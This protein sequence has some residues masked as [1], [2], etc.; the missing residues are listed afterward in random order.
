MTAASRILIIIGLILTLFGCGQNILSSKKKSTVGEGFNNDEIVDLSLSSSLP[1]ITLKNSSAYPL[2]GVCDSASGIVTVVIGTPNVT[3]IFQCDLSGYFSGIMDVSTVTL[4]PPNIKAS[5]ANQTVSISSLVNDQT[6]ISD[7]PTVADQ[8]YK[9]GTQVALGVAC[10]EAGEVVTFTNPSLSP[11]SQT[12]TCQGQGAES[13]TFLFATGQ[14]T[15][16]TNNVTVS[17]VDVNGN[18][19]TNSNE[20]NLP[21]DNVAPTVQVQAGAGIIEGNNASFT[22]SVT[23]GTSFVA[24][25]PTP[26]SGTISSGVCSLSPCT[27]TVTGASVGELTLT[28]A[29]GAVTDVAGNS[30]A[31]LQ[32]DSLL[33]SAPQITGVQISSND[34]DSDTWYETS[35]S[36]SIQ[37][38]YDANVTVDTVG[39]TPTILVTLSSGTKTATYSTGSGSQNLEF[40]MSILADDYQCNGTLDLGGISLNGGTIKG[41]GGG[42]ANNSGLPSSV[43]GAKIDAKNPTA[44]STLNADLDAFNNLSSSLSWTQGTDECGLSNIEYGFGTSSGGLDIQSYIDIGLVETY[45]AEKNIGLASSFN[46]IAGTDYYTSIRSVDN[47]GNLS[48]TAT[49]SAWSFTCSDPWAGINRVIALGS[50][51]K[52]SIIDG[53]SVSAEDS[54]FDDFVQTWQDQSGNNNH[55]EA[56]SSQVRPSYG[57]DNSSTSKLESYVQGD[58]VDDTLVKDFASSIT[59]NFIFYYVLKSLNQA[60]VEFQSYFSSVSSGDDV[61]GFQL[62]HGGSSRGCDGKF[63][64]LIKDIASDPPLSICGSDYDNDQHVFAVKYSEDASGVKTMFLSVDGSETNSRTL[65]NPA[66]FSSLRLFQNRGG[67]N[68]QEAQALE[69]GVATGTITEAQEKQ[70]T[71][72]L[73]CKWNVSL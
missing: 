29:V 32:T 36:I 17:S 11:N 68:F 60:P 48:S 66:D 69:L 24:F 9:N 8:N 41:G 38:Q 44:P 46:L 70:I 30:N 23:D 4:N 55:L 45:Q 33:V 16:N 54:S 73:I 37:V 56:P 58:G 67:N 31:S 42:I 43:A 72:Y 47:A 26:S 50:S 34:G 6:P 12:Y 2:S 5:Q 25:T 10:N 59:G 20:F 14:E 28:V 64:I 53:N 21:I 63:R 13:V 57:S 61:G 19:T 49:S 7:A 1:N 35:D 18:P 39:G 51:N 22:V 65:S 40:T 3:G 71:D 15:L 52:A 27:V 62:D